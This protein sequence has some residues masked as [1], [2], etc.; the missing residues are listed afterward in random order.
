MKG[1]PAIS[2]IYAMANGDAPVGQEAQRRNIEA[3]RAAWHKAGLI[4]LDPE[5]IGDDWLRQ[6]LLNEAESRYGRRGRNA[7]SG[8]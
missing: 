2:R 5:D 1:Q 6:A 7:G 8:F 3:R 4:V